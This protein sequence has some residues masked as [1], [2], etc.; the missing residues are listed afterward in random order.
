MN[1]LKITWI[2]LRNSATNGAIVL[3]VCREAGVRGAVVESFA[4]LNTY[5]GS[6][7]TPIWCKAS[8]DATPHINREWLRTDMDFTNADPDS[9]VD[10]NLREMACGSF[11]HWCD[12]LD[13]AGASNI[14]L[15]YI[16]LE[17]EIEFKDLVNLSTNL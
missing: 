4:G 9:A 15:G 6:M 3:S 14:T 17:G 16:E 2:P 5:E 1:K 7:Q 11:N 8:L 12:G 13:V 10:A